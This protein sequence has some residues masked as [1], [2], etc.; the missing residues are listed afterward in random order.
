MTATGLHVWHIFFYA[1]PISELYTT[2]F[3]IFAVGAHFHGGTSWRQVGHCQSGQFYR[4][5]RKCF[6]TVCCL[7]TRFVAAVRL[8]FALDDSADHM[9][10]IFNFPDAELPIP[11]T[12]LLITATPGYKKAVKGMI[13][14][15]L[16]ERNRGLSDWQVPFETPS[17]SSDLPV[18]SSYG[19][20]L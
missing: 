3:L 12:E 15:C 14:P 10:E 5:V 13:R 11:Y 7:I 20:L 4:S 19:L 16:E 18:W 9:P 8:T 1:V 6:W 17:Q 2:A